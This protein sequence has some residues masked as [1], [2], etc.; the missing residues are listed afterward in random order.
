MGGPHGRAPPGTLDT[1]HNPYAG[2]VGPD[3]NVRQYGN[4]GDPR[5]SQMNLS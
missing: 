5:N 2:G 4:F 1:S 3:P